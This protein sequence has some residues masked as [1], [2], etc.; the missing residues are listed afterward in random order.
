MSHRAM[1][2]LASMGPRRNRR[3][4]LRRRWRIWGL[5][6]M[7]QWGHAEIGVET[8]VRDDV[9][10]RLELLQWGQAEIGVET[11]PRHLEVVAIG[12]SMGPRRN[13]RGDY[14]T[15]HPIGPI[16]SASMGPRRNRRGDS[17]NRVHE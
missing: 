3:G 4:D 8:R 11:T 10:S 1:V 15:K 9:R 5:R 17:E 16:E 12:A 2:S 13:R 14:S 7:L 6:R